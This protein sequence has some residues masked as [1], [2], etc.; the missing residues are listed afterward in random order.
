MAQNRKKQGRE[1]TR[2]MRQGGREREKG[3]TSRLVPKWRKGSAA[4][5]LDQFEQAKIMQPENLNKS[6]YCPQQESCM[7]AF[8][9]AWVN[10]SPMSKSELIRVG[11]HWRQYVSCAALF[12]MSLMKTFPLGFPGLFQNLQPNFHDSFSRVHNTSQMT[13]PCFLGQN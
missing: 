1:R 11:G 13:E 9:R 12:A 10:N 3:K 2:M 7:G 6:N 8:S 4:V 5:I